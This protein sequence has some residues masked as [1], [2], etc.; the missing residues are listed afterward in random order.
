M[1]PSPSRPKE[2]AIPL[3]IGLIAFMFLFALIQVGAVSIAFEKLGLTGGS[4]MLLLLSCIGGSL[5][6]MPLFQMQTSADARTDRPSVPIP[7]LQHRQP[8]FHGRTVVAINVGGAIIPATFCLYLAATQPVP[9][10]GVLLATAGQTAVCYFFSRPVP[11]LG[12]GMPIL[13]API[14]AAVLGVAFGGEHSPAVA[15][16]AGTLGVLAGADLLR[17]NDIRSLGVPVASIGGAGTFDGVFITGIVA[18]LLA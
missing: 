14:A 2:L 13:V 16:I 18:V 9:L 12:I 6:N 11:G 10:L 4:G 5:I 7:W 3:L 15:Y 8:P 1:S 17:I